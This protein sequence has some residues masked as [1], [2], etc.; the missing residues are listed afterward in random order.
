M[1]VM[2]IKKGEEGER[3]RLCSICYF[4]HTSKFIQEKLGTLNSSVL[5]PTILSP[6]VVADLYGI[7]WRIE[8]AFNKVAF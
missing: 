4:T 5:H 1:A 7:R 6:H 8:D 3:L 2:I